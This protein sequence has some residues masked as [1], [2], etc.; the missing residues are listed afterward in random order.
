MPIVGLRPFKITRA[1][2]KFHSK[3]GFE[4]F[5]NVLHM[6]RTAHKFGEPEKSVGISSVVESGL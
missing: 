3:Y 1:A 4:I 5:S 2:E 6:M